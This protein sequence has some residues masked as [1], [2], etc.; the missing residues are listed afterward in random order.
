M[1][2]L[3][4]FFIRAAEGKIEREREKTTLYISFF[5]PLQHSS[6]SSIFSYD[7]GDSE[8]MS[9]GELELGIR[10]WREKYKRDAA[11]LKSLQL[12]R[13]R[14]REAAV[15][16]AKKGAKK[17]S[18]GRGSRGPAASAAPRCRRARHRSKMWTCRSPALFHSLRS[19]TSPRH[20]AT[21]PRPA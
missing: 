15:E 6:S 12:E 9:Q 16:A 21:L 8:D 14:V 2:F 7:D 4:L 1:F 17:G 11:V 5:F 13:E 20:P 10:N 3:F 18:K 19:A